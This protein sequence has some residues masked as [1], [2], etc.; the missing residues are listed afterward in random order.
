M[1]NS[2]KIGVM[3]V[4][5]LV[6]FSYVYK[7]LPNNLNSDPFSN[8]YVECSASVN[9]FIQLFDTHYESCN[10]PRQGSLHFVSENEVFFNDFIYTDECEYNFNCYE[11]KS[12]VTKQ[13]FVNTSFDLKTRTFRGSIVFEKRLV[14]SQWQPG[15]D[16]I[17]QRDYVIIFNKDFTKI[18]AGQE[19]SLYDDGSKSIRKYNYKNEEVGQ[20]GD[21]FYYLIDYMSPHYYV[22]E[23]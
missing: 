12:L 23:E 5:G 18:L 21:D 8:I 22:L 9:Q 19:E 2:L 15:I 1:K 11:D 7:N 6:F 4:A 13:Y 16:K 20:R 14:A 10:H 17:Y 3:L